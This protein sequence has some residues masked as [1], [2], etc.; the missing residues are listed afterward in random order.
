M[1]ITVN[2]TNHLVHKLNEIHNEQDSTHF[3]VKIIMLFN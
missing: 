3:Y 2:V 1:C